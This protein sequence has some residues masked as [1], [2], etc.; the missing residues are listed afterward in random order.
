MG[1]MFVKERDDVSQQR[2]YEKDGIKLKVSL[3]DFS[4]INY[5]SAHNFFLLLFCQHYIEDVILSWNLLEKKEFFYMEN[6]I[7]NICW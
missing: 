3:Q 5:I 7:L 1:W 4:V 6:I 2:L